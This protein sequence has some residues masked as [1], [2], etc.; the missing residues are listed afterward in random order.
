MCVYILESLCKVLGNDK[1][2]FFLKVGVSIKMSSFNFIR[3]VILI[4]FCIIVNKL[5]LELEVGEIVFDGLM[6]INKWNYIVFLEVKFFFFI[7]GF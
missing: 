6:L 7:I 2:V 3:I 1:F 5:S 4:F